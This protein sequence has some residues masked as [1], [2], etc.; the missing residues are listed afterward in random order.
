[1]DI[2][3]VEVAYI[4]RRIAVAGHKYINEDKSD[5]IKSMSED[6]LS[7]PP[8]DSGMLYKLI[9]GASHCRSNCFEP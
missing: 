3:T 4:K 9:T 2:F 6:I 1:M 7:D 5:A 8:W